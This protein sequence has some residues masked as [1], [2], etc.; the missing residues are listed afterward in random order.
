MKK[1]NLYFIALMVLLP[2]QS[3]FAQA[4]KPP[5]P[6]KIGF[7]ATIEKESGVSLDLTV[8]PTVGITK[9]YLPIYVNAIIKIQP[10]ISYWGYSGKDRYYEFGFS[11]LHYGLGVFYA[12]QLDK[13]FVYLGPR[14]ATEHVTIHSTSGGDDSKE[15]KNDHSIGITLGGEYFLGKHFSLGPEVQF[16]YISVGDVD[17]SSDE[18]SHIKATEAVIFLCVY[19][20]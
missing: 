19:L 3:L 13:A 18:E 7:G 10:E 5:V 2:I 8:S 6:I 20:N 15:S 16:N 11:S 9:I 12:K 14:Y 1:P 17:N 4:K